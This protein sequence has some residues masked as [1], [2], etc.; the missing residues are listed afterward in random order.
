[1]QEAALYFRPQVGH[2]TIFQVRTSLLQLQQE[3]YWLLLFIPKTVA[4]KE[5]DVRGS[6]L[7]K[8][9]SSSKGTASAITQPVFAVLR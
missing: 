6:V 3:M 8:Q 9:S 7:V 5:V 2:S 4:S 1:L